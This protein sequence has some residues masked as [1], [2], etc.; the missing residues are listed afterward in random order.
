MSAGERG[1]CYKWFVSWYGLG[2][3]SPINSQFSEHLS[4]LAAADVHATYFCSGHIS[5]PIWGYEVERIWGYQAK[6]IWENQDIR[7]S[8]YEN[9]RI[10]GKE[11]MR[12]RKYEDMRLWRYAHWAIF[13]QTKLFLFWWVLGI[14]MIFWCV[15]MLVCIHV[16]VNLLVGWRHCSKIR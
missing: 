12:I 13:C 8:G 9:M 6:R 16:D 2:S 11:N 10:W 5:V 14:M 7:M 3:A 1:H 4:R 15:F